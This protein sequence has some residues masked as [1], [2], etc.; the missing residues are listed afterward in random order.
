MTEYLI[1]FLILL[2][3]SFAF[4]LAWERFTRREKKPLSSLYVEALRDLL[5]GKRVAAFSKLRQVVTEDSNNL[6][7]Y[8]RLG[9]ILREN[10]K[11][12][13]ALQVHRDLT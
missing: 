5:D 11:P 4:F 12:D 9:Q 7:A 10:K 1:I 3:V 2:A 6:D 13:R 8:L